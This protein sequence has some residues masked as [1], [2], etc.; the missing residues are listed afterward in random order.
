MESMELVTIKTLWTNSSF[1]YALSSSLGN[2]MGILC[3]W[4]LFVKDNV[5]SSDNF[6]VVMGTWVPSSSK[7]LIIYVYASQDLTETREL[8]DCILCLID[9]WDGDYVIMGDLVKLELNKKDMVWFLTF[10][11]AIRGTLVDGEWIVDPYWKLLEHDIVASVKEFFASVTN[12]SLFSGIPIDY[13]LTLSHLFFAGDDIFF[14]KWESLNIR[15]I[16]NVLKC[17]HLASG[18]K[19]N[20]HKSKIIRIGSRQEEVDAATITIG[21]SIFTT[22]FVHLGVKVGGAMSRIKSWDDVLAKERQLWDNVQSK[23]SPTNYDEADFDSFHWINCPYSHNLPPPH[24]SSLPVQPYPKNYLVSTNIGEDKIQNGCDDDTSMDTN[25]E[26]K[27]GAQVED[28]D[29]GDTYDIWGI[30]VEN[31][32][33]IRQFLTLNIPDAMHDVIQPLIPKTI[34]TT[35]HNDGYVAPTTKSNLDEHLEEFRDEILNVTMVDEEADFNP[36]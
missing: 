20:F 5:I 30:T 11:L 35:P 21:C 14:S 3:V 1:N 9:Q 27:K 24:H 2:S 32:E 18:Q 4:D 36:T 23:R 10:K 8:W 25:H 29:D 16:L 22:P 33:R 13:S 12:A 7:L 26:S 28:G 6:L 31:V 19:I 34:H 15:I 17:F